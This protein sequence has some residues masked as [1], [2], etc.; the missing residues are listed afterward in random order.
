MKYR[1]FT[2]INSK[3]RILEIRKPQFRPEDSQL[4]MRKEQAQAQAATARVERTVMPS[5]D[6]YVRGTVIIKKPIQNKNQNQNQ[7]KKTE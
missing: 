5:E 7:N 2:I 1:Q 4:V 6:K 3:P